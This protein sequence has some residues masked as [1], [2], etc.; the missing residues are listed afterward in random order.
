MCTD[1]DPPPCEHG[2]LIAEVDR[3]QDRNARL[4]EANKELRRQLAAAQRSGR[5]QAAPFSKGGR[6]R[7]AQTSGSKAWYR[8]VQLQEAALCR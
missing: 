6:T 7:Q 8:V 2:D 1:R 5:R 4:T 3:L